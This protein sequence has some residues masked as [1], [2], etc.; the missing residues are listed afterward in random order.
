MCVLVLKI[1][2]VSLCIAR[3]VSF[4]IQVFI[5][6]KMSVYQNIMNLAENWDNDNT[7][8][9]DKINNFVKQREECDKK[10]IKIEEEREACEK[11]FENKIKKL[12]SE[13]ITNALND[14]GSI[15]K[16]WEITYLEAAICNNDEY[17]ECCIRFAYE[18]TSPWE[19]ILKNT[20]NYFE[21]SLEPYRTFNED[22]ILAVPGK[23][24][25]FLRENNFDKLL[26]CLSERLFQGYYDK[27]EFVNKE[28]L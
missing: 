2:L 10:I 11:S 23:L 3:N 26:Y 16:K 1:K 5:T 18:F 25:P 6:K 19:V 7:M 12:V 22:G 9:D 28:H 8:F 21:I 13:E 14:S 20:N 27:I 24:I 4:F 15:P 17:F